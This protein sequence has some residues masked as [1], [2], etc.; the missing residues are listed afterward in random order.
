MNG[1]CKFGDR[2]KFEHPSSVAQN[3][4]HVGKT[5]H[6]HEIPN[7]C[8][9]IVCQYHIILYYSVCRYHIILYYSVCQ[10]HIILY[11]S[12]CQC[13][14]ILYDCCLFYIYRIWEVPKTP[15]RPLLLA[16]TV[17][18]AQC[19]RHVHRTACEPAVAGLVQSVARLYTA[20]CFV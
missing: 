12:V 5:A 11:Y 18:T 4:P 9:H 20:S 2:C 14:I 15:R 7:A 8:V 10:C 16:K 6:T 17:R 13:H 19:K 3:R 1:R